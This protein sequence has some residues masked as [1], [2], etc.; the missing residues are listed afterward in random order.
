VTYVTYHFMRAGQ[1][2]WTGFDETRR[3]P[4]E[5]AERIAASTSRTYADEVHVFFA[6]EEEPDFRQPDA[7]A[8][9]TAW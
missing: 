8:R 5:Y 4:Q 3:D 6:R 2:V 7:T 1:V 9:V